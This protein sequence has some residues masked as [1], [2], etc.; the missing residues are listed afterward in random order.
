MSITIEGVPEH[1]TRAQV[2]ELLATLGIDA[3]KVARDG[4]VLIGGEAVRCRVYATDADGHF[5]VDQTTGEVAMH[6][7]C[8]PIVEDQP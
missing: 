2:V 4:G 5:Y 8:I 7:V 1:I 3:S 6:E